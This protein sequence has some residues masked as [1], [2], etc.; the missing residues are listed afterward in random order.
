LLFNGEKMS[1]NP[2]EAF[3]QRPVNLPAEIPEGPLQQTSQKLTSALKEYEP[4]LQKRSIDGD[5][6]RASPLVDFRYQ[7]GDKHYKEAQACAYFDRKTGE[8]LL[9]LDPDTSDPDKLRLRIN[10]D[11]VVVDLDDTASTF[12]DNE[13]DVALVDKAVDAIE[14]KLWH[15]K[16]SRERKVKH[17][18]QV[19]KRSIGTLATLAV[20]GGGGYLG[21]SRLIIEPRQEAAQARAD[22]DH[23]NLQLPGEGQAVESTPLATQ[24]ASD[25]AKIPEYKDGDTLVHARTFDVTGESCKTLDVKVSDDNTVRLTV[26]Q[27]SRLK[28]STYDILRNPNGSLRFCL[29]GHSTGSDEHKVAVQVS[30]P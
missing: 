24:P 13:N 29:D 15:L 20:I 16:T 1:H 19:A 22:Y 28:G 14:Q 2:E 3:W 7:D 17:R 27:N 23:Q 6:M 21:V 26:A 9:G 25:F 18:K 10:S 11:G 30:K 4:F 8:T 12:G 5:K